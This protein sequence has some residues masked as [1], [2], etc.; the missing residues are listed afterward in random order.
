MSTE[1]RTIERK[2]VL[3]YFLTHQYKHVFWVIK[4]TVSSSTQNM[5]WLRNKNKIIISHNNFKKYETLVKCLCLFVL[6][7]LICVQTA[8]IIWRRVWEW[9]NAMQ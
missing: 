6:F 7:D 8:F 5:F 3:G 4:W 1:A 2:I 9:N